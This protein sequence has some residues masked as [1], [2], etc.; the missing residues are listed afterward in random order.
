MTNQVAIIPDAEAEVRWRNWQVRGAE[1]DR[2]T[3]KRMR[4]W[5]L[6]LAAGFLVWIVAQLA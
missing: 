3:A 4:G 1:A 6:L 5:M 2:R